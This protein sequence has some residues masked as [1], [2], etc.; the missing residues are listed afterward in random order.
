LIQFIANMFTRYANNI[1]NTI[2]NL[3]KKQKI[4][5]KDIKYLNQSAEKITKYLGDIGDA[6][7]VICL[8]I[9]LSETYKSG[10]RMP[11]LISECLIEAFINFIINCVGDVFE[12]IGKSLPGV[13][14]IIGFAA[15]FAAEWLLNKIFNS[16]TRKRI[17]ITFRRLIA[18]QTLSIK[19]IATTCIKSLN[20]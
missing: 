20:A 10:G 13:G 4:L 7:Y 3:T 5:L 6:I 12:Y 19:S 15:S 9:I 16:T 14:L 18:V 11:E 2:R 17:A 8:I 1:K